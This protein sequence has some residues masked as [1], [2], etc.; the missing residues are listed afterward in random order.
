VVAF[1]AAGLAGCT[2]AEAAPT[3]E[4]GATTILLD[5]RTPDEFAAGHLDGAV[6][7]P[8][9]WDGFA[10]AITQLDPDADYVVYCRTGRRSA[11][12]ASQME[13]IGLTV[14]DLGSIEEAE[15]A[16]GIAVVR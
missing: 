16:T 7:L 8:V 4:V 2:L 3:V 14:T 13:A 1:A 10:G 5:V 15:R 11:L 12:A 6:N 9:E